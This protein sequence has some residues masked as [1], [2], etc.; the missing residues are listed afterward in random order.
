MS[1]HLVVP[2][3]DLLGDL[4]PGPVDWLCAEMLPLYKENL[5]LIV[6]HFFLICR[7]FRVFHM[8]M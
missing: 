8:Q 7:F 2:G 3:A 5:L 6:N 4:L 1:V